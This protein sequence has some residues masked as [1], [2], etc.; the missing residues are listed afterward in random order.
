[1]AKLRNCVVR[2]F[3]RLTVLS[4]VEGPA[5]GARR[6]R[7]VLVQYVEGL[8][9]EP[10]GPRLVATADRRMQQKSQ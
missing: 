9:G 1:M 5:R 6:I 10:A 2:R 7:S 8:R 4:K 3:D